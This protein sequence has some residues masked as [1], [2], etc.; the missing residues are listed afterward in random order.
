MRAG[1]AVVAG[2]VVSQLLGADY[3]DGILV[4]MIFYI[5]SFYLGRLLWYKDAGPQ[6]ATKV[7]TTG[8]GGFIFLFLFTWIL[9]FTVA[10]A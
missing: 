10:S 6:N 3:A 8:I 2:L 1:F 5:F 7:Y 4:G 9:F